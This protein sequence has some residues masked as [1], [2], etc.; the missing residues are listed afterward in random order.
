MA[1]NWE[2]V[3]LIKD[4]NE[5]EPVPV[6]FVEDMDN[7]K[8]GILEMEPQ[9]DFGYHKGDKIAYFP[10]TD[11]RGTTIYI[12]DMNPVR[13]LTRADLEGGEMLK[14]AI[15]V[16]ENERTEDHLFDVLELLHDSFLWIPCNAVMGEEDQ[17]MIENMLEKAGD[18]LESL[19]GVTFTSQENVR[20]IPD[21]LQ[22]GES[23]FFPVFSSCEEMG[24][25]G[26]NFSKIEKHFLEALNLAKNNE[27][28]VVGIVINAFTEP[29]VLD[30]QLWDMM[31]NMKSIV[32]E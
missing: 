9:Q 23:L 17:K 5:P 13:K 15:T 3:V 16:F 20:L 18:D 12:S 22:N 28:N 31:E 27:A 30:R 1:E 2:R 14:H 7:F 10:F 26:N 29:F 24:E 8:I 11:D 21:I 32:E 19:K 4:P 25:Y 6:S